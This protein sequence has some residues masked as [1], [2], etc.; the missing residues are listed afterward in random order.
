MKNSILICGS[1]RWSKIHINEIKTLDFNK[2]IIYSRRK[3][4]NKAGSSSKNIIH[5]NK[6]SNIDF[7]E[8]K[9]ITLVSSNKNNYSYLSKFYKS[10]NS[11][12]LI[13]KP[14][15]L[16]SNFLEKILKIRKESNIYLSMPWLYDNN[17]KKISRLINTENIKNIKFLWYSNSKM[18]YGFRRKFDKSIYFTQDIISH[19]LSILS[20]LL[21]NENLDF[22][23]K[24]CSKEKN[25]EFLEF[26]FNQYNIRLK[27]NRSHK[28]NK[29]QIVFN[30][31]EG[32]S[33]LINIGSNFVSF[34]H[35]NLLV[36][37]E[38][39]LKDNILKQYKDILTKK[40]KHKLRSKSN[41]KKINLITNNIFY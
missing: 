10:V 40:L 30:L 8:I 27:C 35:N 39:S 33:Y 1:G 25:Y 26:Y 37:K 15:L 5:L 12:I 36:Y 16:N 17:L 6:L 31:F 7:K 24:L 29:K 3:I 9:L 32:G 19:I 11:K 34:Y 2:I 20:I 21:K 41:L 23:I 18:R 4:E 22:K 14:I 28:V 38:R 13:E